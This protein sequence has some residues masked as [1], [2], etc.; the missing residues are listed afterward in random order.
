MEGQSL[1]KYEVSTR[2]GRGAM[3]IVYEAWDPVIARKVA[4]KTLSLHDQ[5]LQD[6]AFRSRFRGKAQAA[7]RLSDPNIVSVF[8][9]GETDE[10][11]YIVMEYV[12]GASLD[13][14][15][16]PG[17]AMPLAETAA[18]MEG[19]LAGLHHSHERGVIHRDI[20][21]SNIILTRGGRVKITDFGIA[22]LDSSGLTQTGTILGTPAYM[23]PEQITGERID[24]RTDLYSAGVVLYRL[25]TG[26]RPFEGSTV[27]IMNHILHTPPPRPSQVVTTAIPE[28]IVI[29]ALTKRPEQRF[30]SAAEFAQALHTELGRAE[31]RMPGPRPASW[32][33]QGR[34]PTRRQAAFVDALRWPCAA[35]MLVAGTVWWLP[36]GPGW[37]AVARLDNAA[38]PASPIIAVPP[39][40]LPMPVVQTAR[41]TEVA[42]APDLAPPAPPAEPARPP[43]PAPL[44]DRVDAVLA[45]APCTLLRGRTDAGG[46][47]ISGVAG[48]YDNEGR[49]RRALARV[50]P[51]TAVSWR[52]RGLYEVPCIALDAL[53]RAAHRARTLQEEVNLALAGEATR[54]LEGDHIVLRLALPEFAVFYAIDDFR[55][56][57]SVVHM[58]SA[59][60]DATR[61]VLMLGEAGG[62]QQWTASAPFGADLIAVVAASAPLL[63]T[64]RPAREAAGPYL[65]D[66]RAAIEH[67]Q[68]TGVR[69]AVDAVPLEIARRPVAEVYVPTGIPHP[70]APK[71]P[72]VV[73]VLPVP[74]VPPEAIR[75]EPTVAASPV[76]TIP[77]LLPV[78]QPTPRQPSA[79]QHF[80]GQPATMPPLTPP[81]LPDLAKQASAPPVPVARVAPAANTGDSGWTVRTFSRQT[82]GSMPETE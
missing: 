54:L 64:E 10:L 82:G 47:E 79:A 51:G 3:G 16:L 14:R 13:T 66:L 4:I 15:L 19:L 12:E 55:P 42:P 36:R 72:R 48:G 8:D 61:P 44:W 23:S 24:L 76:V 77:A 50:T 41:A 34:G 39:A 29:K 2:I 67:S 38:Q 6:A 32:H 78:V 40:V 81:P 35:T 52:V 11:A 65:A 27:S 25:L 5:E 56:D 31:A 28:A 46:L 75:Q 80:L 17:Q 74:G 43:P 70:P 57:G 30:R 37:F 9:Y 59:S 68:A 18:I 58:A 71:P 69:L 63:T 49:V 62:G 33:R 73:H 21:P 7:G 22:H 1:G 60:T 20:K 45:A 53:R 26:R